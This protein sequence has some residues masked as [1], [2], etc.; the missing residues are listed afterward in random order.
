[1]DFSTG[2][3]DPN[4]F[5]NIGDDRFLD[6]EL[7][8]GDGNMFD[9]GNDT[10]QNSSAD[11]EAEAVPVDSIAAAAGSLA[12]AHRAVNDKKQELLDSKV[13][14]WIFTF[15]D[16]TEMGKVKDSIRELDR[17]MRGA[18]PRDKKGFG[19][20]LGQI[21]QSYRT[22]T[23]NC[24]KYV[25]HIVSRG[26][27]KGKSG[28]RR[29]ELVR[30]ILAQSL[31]EQ[32][33]F[34]MPS[35]DLYEQNKNGNSWEDILYSARAEKIS[36]SDKTITKVGAGTST[37]YRKENEDGST[38]Y[39]KAEEKLS[40]QG[41]WLTYID[42]YA[43]SGLPGA[44]E[45]AGVIREAYMEE[46]NNDSYEDMTE[47]ER[48]LN[49]NVICDMLN[50]VGNT[51][52][53]EVRIE[54]QKGESDRA[55]KLRVK[56]KIAEYQREKVDYY[57]SD[58][59]S[60]TGAYIK[61]HYDEFIEMAKYTCKKHNE[62]RVATGF[63]LIDAGETISNRNVSTSRMAGKY[64]MG[65]VV[66]ESKTVLI[67]N[68][69][70][71]IIKANSMEGIEG[72]TMGELKKVAKA[73][74]ITVTLTEN[75]MR[76]LMQLQ[77]FDLI[78]GQIDRHLNN[79]IPIYEITGEKEYTVTAI[80]A[81]DNDMSFGSGMESIT[82]NISNQKSVLID[83]KVTVP[84]LPRDFYNSIMD[85]TPEM[86]DYDQMDIRSQKEL[87]ALGAR[88][89]AMQNQLQQL[90]NNKKIILLDTEAEWKEAKKDILARKKSGALGA[91]YLF[92]ALLL[93]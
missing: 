26:R 61:D 73:E 75:A 30:E 21:R 79:Y 50:S 34:E 84:Y 47:M 27:G 23:D 6:L 18:M 77:V 10:E 15:S 65:D 83:D 17:L 1:M 72:K 32:A 69:D 42:E 86:A 53:E 44:A 4:K 43:S 88:I 24:R 2:E 25:T 12:E 55:Y 60:K 3:F 31:N 82:E 48:E 71:S 7:A 91:G 13:T 8:R 51:A 14:H 66:A 64:G 63:A 87:N 52:D 29:L 78:C 70:G 45:M 85:Y 57:M 80:K 74:G 93:S 11:T 81:I 36:E 89:T 28:A 49:N 41:L 39:I 56:Q 16:S 9:F 33:V 90:V 22:M 68:D 67:G 59:D 62:F 19:T 58:I 37:I 20:S 5:Q 92:D 46:R 35:T 76:Q 40:D 38:S 54:R